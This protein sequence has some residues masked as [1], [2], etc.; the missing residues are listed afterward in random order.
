MKMTIFTQTEE[1]VNFDNLT[2]ITM[3]EGTFG[4]VPVYAILAYPIGVPADEE[5]PDKLIQL[6]VFTDENNCHDAY[7]KLMQLLKRGVDTVFEVPL[8]T[9]EG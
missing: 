3:L 2:K 4:D 6:G 5:D 9:D 7:Q 1:I 8:D